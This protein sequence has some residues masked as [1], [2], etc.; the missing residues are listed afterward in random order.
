MQKVIQGGNLLK[1]KLP[2]CE[3]GVNKV[4][5]KARVL[6]RRSKSGTSLVSS[7][8]KVRESRKYLTNEGRGLGGEKGGGEGYRF[9]PAQGKLGG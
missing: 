9:G 4:M 3:W 1:R 5:R 2:S 8:V 7:V 6:G